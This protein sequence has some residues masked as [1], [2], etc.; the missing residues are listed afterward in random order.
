MTVGT[1]IPSLGPRGEGWVALQFVLLGAIAVAGW[2]W[3]GAWSGIARDALLVVGGLLI[4][5]GFA[6]AFLGVRDLDRSLSAL[7]RPTN[8]AVLVSHGVY[9]QLRHPIYAG[10][11]VA[12]IGWSLITASLAAL[13][14]ALGL[15]T[16]LDL[17]SRREEVWLRERFPD[18]V[19][20]AT[21]TKRFMP[22]LY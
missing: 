6:L 8:Q 16:V 13:A 4:I 12:A 17:K 11:I 19:A 20:Y 1:R 18:Y 10:L 22:S 3:G 2:L 14:L 15:A 5:G 9:R 7:P 21:R